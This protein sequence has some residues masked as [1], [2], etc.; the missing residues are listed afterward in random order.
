MNKL[1]RFEL[2]YLRYLIAM[3]EFGGIRK[4]A[5][6]LG[7]QPST[8]SRRVRDL[9]DDIGAALFIRTHGGVSLTYAGERFLQQAR[10]A[11]NHVNYAAQEAGV[12]GRGQEG[13]VRIGL[14][15][16]LASGFLPELVEAYYA[17]HAGVR[18]EYVEGGTSDHVPAVQQHRLDVAFLTGTTSAE[19]CDVAHLWDERIYVVMPNRHELAEK[20]E[21]AWH[22]LHGRRFIVSEAQPGPEIHDYLVKHLSS[23]GHSPNIQRQAVYRDT[24]M[25]IVAGGSSLTLTSEATIAAQL[26]GIAYRPL[27]GEI[28]SFCAVWS[29]K[30]DNPAFRRLLSLAKVMSKRSGEFPS[31]A[32]NR[33]DEASQILDPSQ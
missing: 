20:E 32:Q 12:I 25:Q 26:P 4:A 29:P 15:S 22:D 13:V 16:S 6:A 21:I 24:L 9:E 1:G 33:S 5:R 10:K 31:G 19:G 11:I 2:R 18:L 27:A 28:L 3:A 17:D 30:N 23:L 7:V 8:V 14:I